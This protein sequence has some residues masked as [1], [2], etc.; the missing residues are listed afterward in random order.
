VAIDKS[1]TKPWVKGVLIFLIVAFV[2]SFVSLAANPW[3]AFQAPKQTAPTQ[4]AAETVDAQFQPQVA[5]ITS[6]L[7]S[8]PESYTALVSLGNTYFDWAVQKQQAS[9]N[10]TATQGADLPLWTGAKDAYARAVAVKNDEPTVQVDYAITLFYTGDSI[11]AIA[12]V[13]DVMKT[14]PEFAPAWFN[15]GI[16]YQTTRD[17]AKATAAFEQYLKLDPKGSTGG[18]PDFAKQQL[19]ELKKSSTATTTP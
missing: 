16:F 7:Q 17:I 15:A 5:A 10:S 14:S 11:K 1:N 4:T 6:V 19:A 12:V 2:L 8:D 3:T 18:S 9:K 13:E